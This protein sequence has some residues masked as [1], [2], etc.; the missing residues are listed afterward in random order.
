MAVAHDEDDGDEVETEVVSTRIPVP[1]KR[2]MQHEAIDRGTNLSTLVND[3]L[4]DAWEEYKHEHD[5][6]GDDEE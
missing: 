4:L 3:L 6:K 1:I 2:E 5:V